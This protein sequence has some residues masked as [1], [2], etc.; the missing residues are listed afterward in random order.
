MNPK[1]TIRPQLEEDINSQIVP[2]YYQLSQGDIIDLASSWGVETYTRGFCIFNIIKYLK[3]YGRKG[4][5]VDLAKAKEY[6][7]RLY[8]EE[9]KLVKQVDTTTSTG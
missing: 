4:G 7:R 6:L 5:L 8:Q 9:E 1:I 2:D 3:R